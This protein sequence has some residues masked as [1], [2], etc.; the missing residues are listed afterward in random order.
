MIATIGLISVANFGGLLWYYCNGR[1]AAGRE[2]MKTTVTVNNTT[3]QPT[4]KQDEQLLVAELAPP[5]T[6]NRCG[7]A[8]VSELTEFPVRVTRPAMPTNTV[9]LTTKPA[10][11]Y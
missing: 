2:E 10:Y 1:T 3:H 7:I 6:T 4:N 5:T 8:E 11:H 9:M